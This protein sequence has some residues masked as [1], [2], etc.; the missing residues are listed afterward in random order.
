[1]KIEIFPHYA[2]HVD[3]VFPAL[4]LKMGYFSFGKSLVRKKAG[5]RW[6]LYIKI[7]FKNN[8]I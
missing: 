3:T 7:K 8:Y 5:L 1:M 4:Y 2:G 6:L